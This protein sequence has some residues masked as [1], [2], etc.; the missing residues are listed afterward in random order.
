MKTIH[1]RVNDGDEERLAQ[2]VD[3]YRKHYERQ[4]KLFPGARCPSVTVS[5]AVRDL[6]FAWEQGSNM[7]KVAREAKS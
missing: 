6:V 4:A 2:L 5:S 7:P 1:I 3:A